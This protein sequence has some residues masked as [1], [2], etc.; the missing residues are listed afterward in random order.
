LQREIKII[1]VLI[2]ITAGC[3]VQ[4]KVGTEKDGISGTYSAEEF[5]RR[6]RENNI[7]NRSFYIRKAEVEISTEKIR[8]NLIMTVKFINIDSSAINI[9]T[10]TGFEIG[11]V[12]IGRD[13]I[14]LID[15]IN[16][17]QLIMSSDYLRRR[18]G[19]EGDLLYMIFG[20]LLIFPDKIKGKISCISGRSE[21]GYSCD[22]QV[23][24]ALVDCRIMKIEEIS[25][26]SNRMDKT[27]NMYFSEFRKEQ[28][29]ILPGSSRIIIQEDNIQLVIRPERIEVG[30]NG[31]AGFSGLKGY[32][33]KILK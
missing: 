8:H 19:L 29:V 18:Y 17:Q 24:K 2:L 21:N 22:E 3:S 28:G 33:T 7:T 13:T 9:R 32:R 15:R 12:F 5:Y 27:I 20:D 10:K 26:Q 11:R 4:R 31:N 25:I 14:T 6:I 1:I 16:K 30:W 23:Y